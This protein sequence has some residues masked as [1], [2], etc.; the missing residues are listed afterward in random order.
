M[1][2]LVP[3][4]NDPGC[5]MRDNKNMFPYLMSITYRAARY[6]RKIKNE[7]SGSRINSGMTHRVFH[8]LTGASVACPLSR[9]SHPV[10][11]ITELL[12]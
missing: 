2:V 9:I 11:R 5:E 7:L 6:S 12:V 8:G 3:Y 4:D 10:S 1:K